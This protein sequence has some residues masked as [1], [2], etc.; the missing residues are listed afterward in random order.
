MVF[1]CGEPNEQVVKAE[2]L[3]QSEDP[4][5]AVLK[6]SSLKRVPEPVEYRQVAHLAET[7]RVFILG[8][9]FGD[10]LA[11]NHANPNITIGTGS[12]SSIRKDKS[13]KVV[14]V[15]IDGALNPGNSGGPVVDARGNLVGIA[16]QTIQGS[17]IGL[18]IPAGELTAMLEGGLGKPTIAVTGGRESLPRR[19]TRLWCPVFDPLKKLKSASVHFVPRSVPAD[20]AQGRPAPTRRRG[21]QPETR[22]LI[23][24]WD[25]PGG[26]PFDAKASP[27]IKQVTVQASFVNGDGKTVYLEPQVV[28]LPA[29]VQVSITTDEN[30]ATTTTVTETQ[31]ERRRPADVAK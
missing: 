17:H 6:V 29:P 13:G 9:P 30:G 19:N 31:T 25:R 2:V 3:C 11:A 20:P 14:R 1:N 5:L 15:Q 7:M 23:A 16:V 21:G 27:T 12:V 8:F 24:R 28:A 4:D 26:T 10:S 22:P 18:T